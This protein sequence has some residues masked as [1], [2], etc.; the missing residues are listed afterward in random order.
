[1][2]MSTSLPRPPL[3]LMQPELSKIGPSLVLSKSSGRPGILV[4]QLATSLL[5]RTSQLSYTGLRLCLPYTF[6]Y[7]VVNACAFS[8]LKGLRA[9]Q[10]FSASMPKY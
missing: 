2:L 6:R 3:A 10:H 5:L 8:D 7:I 9:Q 1:M 4:R